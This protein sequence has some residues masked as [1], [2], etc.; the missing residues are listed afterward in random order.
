VVLTISTV[1]R[2][3]EDVI[4][5]KEYERRIA[6]SLSRL[7]GYQ[8]LEW[9][10]A[11][12]DEYSVF[13]ALLGKVY[14]DFSALVVVGGSGDRSVPYGSQGGGR[15]GA[16]WGWLVSDFDQSGRVAVSSK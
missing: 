3:D 6:S 9:L 5:G 13:M 15:W 10:I 4:D 7:L 8:H 16:D 11:H 2:I 1:L 14:I 12:Q